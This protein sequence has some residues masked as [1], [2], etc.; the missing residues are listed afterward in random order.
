[1]KGTLHVASFML[2]SF[3][4]GFHHPTADMYVLLDLLFD[5]VCVNLCFYLVNKCLQ[6]YVVYSGVSCVRGFS[7]LQSAFIC[8]T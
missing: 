4:Q 7:H 6:V 2:G 8:I 1:M 5:I 3:H